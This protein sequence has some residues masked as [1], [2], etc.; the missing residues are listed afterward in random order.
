VLTLRI[1][2]GALSTP[3][4][5]GLALAPNEAPK[6][7]GSGYD[8][9]P[10]GLA[11]AKPALLS[12]T[13][14]P[15][16]LDVPGVDAIALAFPVGATWA[17][18]TGGRIDTSARTLTIGLS[19][20]SAAP[21]KSLTA[22]RVSNAASVETFRYVVVPTF[23]FMVQRT[24]L[25]T[26]GEVILVPMLLLPPSGS[27]EASEAYFISELTLNL[28]DFTFVT[29]KIG[30]VAYR[31]GNTLLYSAPHSIGHAS[32]PVKLR[33][34]VTPRVGP[35][36][37]FEATKVVHVVR[38]K[39][40]LSV[41]FKLDLQCVGGN[42][43]YAYAYSDSESENFIL[44]NDLEFSKEAGT[45]HNTSGHAD[46]KNC[47]CSA[48]MVGG[49]GIVTF[50][51]VT[52][53]LVPEPFAHFRMF[54][55]AQI[56]EMIPP[57]LWHCPDGIGGTVTATSDPVSF[58]FDLFLNLLSVGDLRPSDGTPRFI[59][60]EPPLLTIVIEWHSVAE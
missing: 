23:D 22:D 18:L 54:G 48:S 4:T 7:I 40:N 53:S 57:I 21:P 35:V 11:F 46:L 19:S 27:G 20:S 44:S 30:T 38:R 58:G 51:S 12:L 36:K 26:D 59:F 8:V 31:T 28:G 2:A 37:V 29:P 47:K 14:G 1:P 16:G 25:P 17:G 5:I 3:V 33:M 52:G 55:K 60:L 32:V 41:E 45:A 50:E 43:D 42:Q 15:G 34:R 13:Y 56:L 6:G 39:W 9:S 24:W 49:P 10:A